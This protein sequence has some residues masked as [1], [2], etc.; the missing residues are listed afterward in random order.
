VQI[1]ILLGLPV[2]LSTLLEPALMLLGDTRVRKH[3]VIAGLIGWTA[4]LAGLQT[5]MW[6]LLGPLCLVA[7]VPRP[8]S[9]G[10][11]VKLNEN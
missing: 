2:A 4:G 6:L 8:A 11:V 10:Q 9:R 3:L 5:A 1:G 7:F